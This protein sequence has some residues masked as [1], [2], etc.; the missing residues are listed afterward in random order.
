MSDKKSMTLTLTCPSCESAIDVLPTQDAHH[1]QC[2]I[3]QEQ[4]PV[5]FNEDHMN[6]VLKDCPCCSR[7]DFYKQ[8]DFKT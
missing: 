5:A 3:C 4:V 1:A 6:G 2:D 8:R 7:K